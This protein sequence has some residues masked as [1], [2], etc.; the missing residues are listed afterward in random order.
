M[1]RA[2]FLKAATYREEMAAA[3]ALD[4]ELDGAMFLRSSLRGQSDDVFREHAE[5]GTEYLLNL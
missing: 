1:P 5:R 3:G 2:G 4:D